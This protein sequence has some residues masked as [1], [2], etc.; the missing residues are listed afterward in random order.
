[1]VVAGGLPRGKLLGAH[2]QSRVQVMTSCGV[3]LAGWG[4]FEGSSLLCL[5]FAR[6]M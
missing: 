5:A 1:M 2:G 4:L 3:K 6:E